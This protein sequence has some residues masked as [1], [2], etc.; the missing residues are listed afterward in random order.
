MAI[1]PYNNEET[2]Q[3]VASEPTTAYSCPTPDN[4]AILSSLSRAGKSARNTDRFDELYTKLKEEAD[5]KY[6]V[7]ELMTTDE[8]FGKVRHIVNG[9]YEQL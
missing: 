1:K 9:L 2:S 7:K 4:N 5:K 3:S 8:F 6:G